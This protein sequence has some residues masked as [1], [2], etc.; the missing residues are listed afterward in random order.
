MLR[1]QDQV[2]IVTGAA[3]SVGLATARRLAEEGASV[4]LTD[5]SDAGERVAAELRDE[6]FEIAFSRV[7]VADDAQVAGMVR[8]A[9]ERWGRLD[10][11]VANAGMSGR[12]SA[13]TV[14]LDDWQRVLDVNLTSVLL[15]TRHAA[16]AMR[17]AGGGAIVNT[18]S[19]MGAVSTLG[20]APYCAS[21][22]GVISLTRATALDHA[23]DNIRV[24]AVCPGFLDE[25]VRIGG[26]PEAR[27]AILPELIAR[28]PLGR[29]GRGDEVAAAIAFLASR[30]ASF[31]TG[32]CLFVDGGY[33]AQ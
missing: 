28:H 2:A 22:G 3:G 23:G 10:V 12:G 14:T 29:L 33:T 18:A 5:L 20:A 25:P 8:L 11:M 17:A 27:L 7:D 31:I 19:V 30:D 24:N 6:G 16:A 9:V 13:E 4:L 26:S 32:T 21:K 1:F 15:C